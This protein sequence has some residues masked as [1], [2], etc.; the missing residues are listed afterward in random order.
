MTKRKGTIF[1]C[2]FCK[3]TLSEKRGDG[4]KEI[5]KLKLKL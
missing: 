4:A 1:S 3:N 5:K 2:S